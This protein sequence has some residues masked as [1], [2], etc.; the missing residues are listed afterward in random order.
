MALV[1]IETISKVGVIRLNDPDRL[2]AMSLSMV[3]ALDAAVDDLAPRTR[4]LVLTASGRA[5]SAGASL[6]GSS[7]L[8]GEGGP[9]DVGAAL[10]THINPLMRK[11]ARLPIPWISAV[12]GPAAGVGC[13]LAL[14]ADMVVAAESAYF[15]QA[16]GR[17]G[18]VPDGGSTWLLNRAVGRVR[19]LELMLLGERLAAPSA[20]AWGL[21]NRVVPDNRLQIEALALAGQLAA[22]PTVALGLMRRLAW[23]AA[24][25]DFETALTDERVA[26]RAAGLTADAAEGVRAFSEKRA[27]QFRGS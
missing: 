13:S 21:I 15:L 27:P 6:S 19:A 9:P 23:D 11:L 5:F 4:A 17:I 25:G 16:F 1:E 18:L 3:E 22:G 2:N 26:Q 8:L 12:P 14:A 20:L 24:D 10:E 7:P